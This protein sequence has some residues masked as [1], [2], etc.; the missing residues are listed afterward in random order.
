MT[1]QQSL[2]LDGHVVIVTGGSSGIGLATC[3]AL[4][5]DGAHVVVVDLHQERIDQ[6]LTDLEHCASTNNTPHLGLALDVRSEQDMQAMA[7]RTLERFG[8]IDGLVACAGILRGKGSAPKPLV[9]ISLDEWEQVIDTNLKGM[10]LSNRAVLPTMTKQRRGNIIN[11]S[12]VSGKEGRAHDAPYCASKFGVV[13]MSESLAE[14]V[15]N[16]GIRVQIVCP[17]AVATPFWEQN[18]PVPMPNYALAPDRI[19]YVISFLLA[20][21]EDMMLVSP[22]VAPFRTRKR[23][24]AK[25]SAA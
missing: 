16:Q 23:A 1:N 12:S 13:G 25:P 2:Q 11:V 10:F 20:L 15:R 7:D 19:A 6:V 5:R 14:E 3:Q 17:D 8:R 9:Q 4:A 24:A 22:I 21:P 18:A